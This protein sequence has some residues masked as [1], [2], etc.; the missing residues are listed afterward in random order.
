MG[1]EGLIATSYSEENEEGEAS[2]G[3]EFDQNAQ[4]NGGLVEG[5]R[6]STRY[7]WAGY[8]CLS[9]EGVGVR[10]FQGRRKEMKS[11][12]FYGG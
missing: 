6:K 7:G 1:G 10:K 2:I 5:R 9:E 12:G 4:C 3:G 8:S 11:L